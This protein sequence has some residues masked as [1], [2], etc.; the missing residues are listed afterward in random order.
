VT[1]Q[2]DLCYHNMNL[3]DAVGFRWHCNFQDSDACLSLVRDVLGCC[4]R[5]LLVAALV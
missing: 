3:I 4:G 2:V 5:C 1:A